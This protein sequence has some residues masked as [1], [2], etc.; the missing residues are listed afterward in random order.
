M[1]GEELDAVN[2]RHVW[3]GIVDGYFKTWQSVG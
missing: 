1:E 3:Y 2:K